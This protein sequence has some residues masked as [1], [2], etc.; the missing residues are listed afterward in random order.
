MRRVIGPRRW[1][2][3]TALAAALVAAAPAALAQSPAPAPGR[4]GGPAAARA[5]IESSWMDMSNWLNWWPWRDTR[6]PPHVGVESPHYGD[7]LFHFFQGRFFSSVT[8]LMVSQHFARMSP[9]DDEAEILRG[10]LFLSY[11]LHRE[12]GEVFARLIERGAAPSVRDRAWYYLA[13]IR[14]QRGLLA[15]AEEALGRIE[16][17]LAGDL[18]EDRAL[19]TAN[20]L[21]ARTRYADAAQLL[22]GLAKGTRASSYARYNLGVALVKS[23]DLARGTTLLDEVGKLPAVTDEFRGLRDQA[24]VALGFA[25]LLEG[26]GEQARGYLQRVR[27]EGM[28]SNKALLGF[29]WAA[30]EQGRMHVALVPWTELAKR[31]DS[32]AAVLEARLAVPY[33]YAELGATGQALGLYEDAIAAFDRESAQL[34]ASVA[35]IRDGALVDALVAANPGE[36]MGWFWN[37]AELPQAQALPHAAR[38]AP[39]LATHEFQEAFKNYR[40]LVFLGGNLQHWQQSL[41]VLRDM[42]DN[43]RAAY[44]ERLPQVRDRAWSGELAGLVERATTLGAELDAVE[45]DGDAAALATPRE[46]ELQARLDRVRDALAA[47]GADPE[48][49]EARARHRRAAGALLWQQSDQFAV[50]LWSARKGMQALQRELAGAQ[51]RDAAL[52]QAQL[53]E[54]ARLDAFAARIEALAARVDAALPRVTALA[55]EQRAAVQELAVADLLRQKERLAG[56]VTQARFAVAQIVDR[57]A[58]SK[59]GPRAAA[60]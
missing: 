52:A 59:E 13:K 60:Q 39:L 2:R 48:F 8:A 19:L 18:E 29:G 43:R 17:P 35:A 5:A 14:Y 58:S 56:Y 32:D 34:D 38:L 45:R 53:D 26:R 31:D 16:K 11:G 54:P 27:L 7:S 40:D 42:L 44:A 30:A 37:I 46:R 3:A 23:G 36:E 1:I 41:D 12:A 22:D 55:Q 15:Q 21:M 24:N 47:A 28:H 20:V 6:P 10:G 33:A 50:R 49:A 51:M 25:A 4:P 9:H 57:A